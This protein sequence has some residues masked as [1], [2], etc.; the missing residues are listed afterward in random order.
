MFPFAQVSIDFPFY[1]KQIPH[2]R[3]PKH[4]LIKQKIIANKETH[5]RFEMQSQL[6]CPDLQSP[7]NKH[8]VD[9]NRLRRHKPNKLCT[10]RFR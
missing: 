10:D 7:D 3:L 4:G 1:P 2:K 9:T 8:L 5:R 6:N